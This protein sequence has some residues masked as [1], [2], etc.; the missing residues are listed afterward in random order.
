MSSSIEKFL[1][2]SRKWRVYTLLISNRV[3]FETENKVGKMLPKCEG[4]GQ[5]PTPTLN[6]TRGRD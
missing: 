6:S 5:D 4:K 2:C 3:G 1:Y